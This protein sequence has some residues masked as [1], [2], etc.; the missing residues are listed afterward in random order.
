MQK[1]TSIQSKL[2]KW[3]IIPL[4]FFSIL[5]FYFIYSVLDKRVNSFFD[6]R[7]YAV[8]KSIE[9]SIGVQQGELIVDLPNFS[10]DFLSTNDEGLIY[11][12]VVDEHNEVLVGWNGILKKK[13]FKNKEM[14]FYDINYYGTPLRIITLK[15]VIIGSTKNYTAYVSLAE[16][17]EERKTNIHEMVIIAIGIMS[18]VAIFLISIMIIAVKKG[19][20]PLHKLKNIIKTRDKRDLN[21]IVFDTPK[22]IEDVVN[23]IN[24]LLKRSRE[25]IEYIEHFNSDVSHQLRTPLAEIKVKIEQNFKKNDKEY[26]PLMDIID[27]MS[28]LVEQLLL[29]AKTNPN[30]INIKTFKRIN[31][32]KFAKDYSMKVVPRIYAKNFEFAFEDMKTQNFIYAD[33]ILL[34]SM[35]NNIVNNA[36]KYAVDKNGKA[37]G[38]I[39]LELQKKENRVC[40]SI[41]DE[42]YGI[43]EN[44]LK[45]I[46]KRSFRV[47]TSKKGSGLG[48]SIVRQIAI[49]HQADVYAKNDNGL[50]ISICI[51]TIK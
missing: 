43:S 26:K 9:Q 35:L 47:D 17:L 14:L 12:S 15:T 25:N 20:S 28:H 45:N 40:I 33:P 36:L 11:Y 39:L 18:I 13:T 51:P 37:M 30:S 23:S 5:L 10:I 16:S 6:D 21:P 27:S 34:E 4:G 32:N 19:L 7:L 31:I 42:G 3:L 50:K 48:L 22:E 46:F 41:K 29:Y 8:A 44:H 24:I 38:T 49:L 2:I 1:V